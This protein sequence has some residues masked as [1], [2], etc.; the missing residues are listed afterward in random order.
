MWRWKDEEE[1]RRGREESYDR[2][3]KR[4]EEGE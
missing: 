2:R 3:G 1:R 4:R